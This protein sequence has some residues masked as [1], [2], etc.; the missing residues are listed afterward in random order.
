MVGVTTAWGAVVKSRSIR[1]VENQCPPAFVLFFITHALF[2]P[3][4]L[5]LT[6]TNTSIY[7]GAHRKSS[8]V[9]PTHLKKKKGKE[10]KQGEKKSSFFL[11]N[12]TQA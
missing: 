7:K 2:I 3:R 12:H 4:E 5:C 1:R 8:L 9:W 10:R 11:S 6:Y